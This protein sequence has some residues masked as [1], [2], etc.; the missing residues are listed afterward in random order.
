M[1]NGHFD[2]SECV[3][4]RTLGIVKNG[5]ST[6]IY[7]HICRLMISSVLLGNVVCFLFR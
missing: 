7:I 2:H 5:I 3:N 6:Y 4:V 1:K